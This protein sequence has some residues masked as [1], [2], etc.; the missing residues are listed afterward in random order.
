MDNK[1]DKNDKID[2]I[3]RKNEIQLRT[4]FLSERARIIRSYYPNGIKWI[5]KKC[6]YEN[7]VL[8]FQCEI[9]ENEKEYN[10]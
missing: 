10:K 8:L 6:T 1:E 2:K 7:T 9:C 4:I 5:C 3:D